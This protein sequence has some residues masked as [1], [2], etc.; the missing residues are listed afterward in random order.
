M[1]NFKAIRQLI[2]EILHLKLCDLN[3]TFK[4]LKSSKILRQAERLYTTSYY[5]FLINFN[6]N[7]LRLWK[8]KTKMSLTLIWPFIVIHGQILSGKL[9]GQDRICFKTKKLHDAINLAS[10]SLLLNTCNMISIIMGKW[11]KPDLSDL[12]NDLLNNS[13]KSISWQLINIIPKKLYARNKEK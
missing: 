6:N 5:V 10:T 9:K 11:A 8:G 3:L 13:M 7:M 12:E 1:Q 4:V 2:V